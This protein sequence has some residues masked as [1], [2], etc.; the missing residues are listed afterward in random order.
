MEPG[1]R[2]AD[3]DL[4]IW[5]GGVNERIA[6]SGY[7]GDAVEWLKEPPRPLDAS[8]GFG[9]GEATAEPELD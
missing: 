5:P 6:R 8:F 2:W 7:H 3:V 9:L 4:T 1:G